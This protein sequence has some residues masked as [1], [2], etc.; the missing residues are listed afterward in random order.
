MILVAFHDPPLNPNSTNHFKKATTFNF[1][2]GT[3]STSFKLGLNLLA[4]VQSRRYKST[5]QLSN[6]N[7][8]P[9]KIRHDCLK[10]RI[11]LQ[12]RQLIK[13]SKVF[14]QSPGSYFS[15]YVFTVR[16]NRFYM[17]LKQRKYS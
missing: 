5:K 6:N 8:M 2:Q 3:A 1:Q 7:H 9:E 11:Y 13:C 10:A 16:C 4:D 12:L 15:S 17:G 14:S